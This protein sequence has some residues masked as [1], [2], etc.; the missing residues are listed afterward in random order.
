MPQVVLAIV[1]ILDGAPVLVRVGI[2]KEPLDDAALAD[3]STAQDD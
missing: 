3:P 1:Q 2:H